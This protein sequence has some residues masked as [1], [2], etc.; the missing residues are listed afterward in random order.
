MCTYNAIRSSATQGLCQKSSLSTALCEGV[1]DKIIYYFK[2]HWIVGTGSHDGLC[3]I[4]TVKVILIFEGA[5]TD[6]EGLS[7]FCEVGVEESRDEGGG[8][9][10]WWGCGWMGRWRGAPLHGCNLYALH[11]HLPLRHIELDLLTEPLSTRRETVQ[12][13][14]GRRASPRLQSTPFSFSGPLTHSLIC[15]RFFYVQV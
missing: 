9:G 15:C 10:E 6:S 1:G 8:S 3:Q 2:I 7:P 4:F 14:I 12:N 13:V 11:S 5:A